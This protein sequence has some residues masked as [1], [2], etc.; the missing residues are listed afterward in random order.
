MSS[1]M[2][3]IDAFTYMLFCDG[4]FLVAT[5]NVVESLYICEIVAYLNL[6][7]LQFHY[8]T[9]LGT[10]WFIHPDVKHSQNN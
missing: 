2:E 8:T 1:W 3:I 7:P 10:T 9:S 4:Y 6:V 5:L